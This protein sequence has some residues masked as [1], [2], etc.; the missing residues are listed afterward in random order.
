[1]QDSDIMGLPTLLRAATFKLESKNHCWPQPELSIGQKRANVSGLDCWEVAGPALALWKEIA[2]PIAKVLDENREL[3][4]QG[5]SKPRPILLR[6]WMIGRNIESATPNLVIVSRSRRQRKAA[7]AFLNQSQ[8]MADHPEVS[9]QTREE[10]APVFRSKGYGGSRAGDPPTDSSIHVVEAPNGPCGALLSVGSDRT[11]T[12]SGVIVIRGKY[13]ALMAQHACLDDQ[14]STGESEEQSNSC[15][16]DEDSDDDSIEDV[17]I[18]SRGKPSYLT[19][20]PSA[21]SSLNRKRFRRR[22]FRVSYS[23][24]ELV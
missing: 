18:T 3:I 4:E 16:F 6:M 5:E 7:K 21:C 10:I 15:G 19:T 17:E 11:T 2:K 8:I 12:L 24:G 13:Y 22:G 1:M 9:I 23:F 14:M 20:L